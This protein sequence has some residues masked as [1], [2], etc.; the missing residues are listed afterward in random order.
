MQTP[1]R[2]ANFLHMY[3]PAQQQPD[4]LE[5]IVAQSYRPI[6][7][8][9]RKNK[10]VRLTLNINGSLLEL[11]DRYG[12][13]DVID[14]LRQLGEAHQIEFTSS[15]KYHAL[16][17]FLNEREIE[18][19]I[20]I[21]TDTLS[22]FLGDK[23]KFKGFF[24]TEMAYDKKILP[25]IS[26]MGFEWLIIDE[27]SCTGEMNQVDP[28]TLY[29]IADTNLKV[30][31]RNRRLSNLIMSAA[32]RSPEALLEATHDVKVGDYV[33]TAM[34]IETFGHHR[35]GLEKVMFEVFATPGVELLQLSDVAKLDWNQKTVTPVP[36]TWAS[37]KQDIENNSQFLSW[38]DPQN[39]IHPKQWELMALVLQAVDEMDPTSPEYAN[40][41]QKMNVALASDHFWWASAKPW[42]SLEMIEDGAFRLID[43]LRSI[44]GISTQ[45]LE[46]AHQLY[47]H[48]TTT[49]FDWQRT[50]KI[51]QMM[52]DQKVLVRIPFK[53]RT[54]NADGA[55]NSVYEAFI[56]LMRQLETKAVAK[57]E[58]EKAILWRDAVYKL[59]HNLDIYDALNAIELV[60]LEIPDPE[61]AAMIEKYKERYFTIRGGQPEQRGS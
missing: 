41:R 15:A 27:I 6:V 20:S 59:E 32:V 31:F 40:V 23:M 50:G 46:Q 9:L 5:A 11:F 43:T 56:E 25:I 28:H 48:I 45:K 55:G 29:S 12:Y 3:Q 47:E 24:P 2:W 44:P 58:Y 4:I 22:F 57:R 13:H 38:S 35:P 17:P 30:F 61:I 54:A 52:V 16:L 1:F 18:R 42:W 7:E 60:R 53:A 34:D 10:H 51:R 26:A 37:S 39:T 8:G 19:Q 21:N 36:A 33:V 49:A 14:S